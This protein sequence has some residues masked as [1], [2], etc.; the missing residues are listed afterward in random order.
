MVCQSTTFDTVNWRFWWF[1]S[2]GCVISLPVSYLIDEQISKWSI[3]QHLHTC[4]L[5]IRLKIT[6]QHNN[7]ADNSQ[8]ICIFF[9]HATI[10]L[11]CWWFS[12]LSLFL[13]ERHD[14]LFR[15]FHVWYVKWIV[16]ELNLTAR[17]NAIELRC[18][19]PK[20]Q[21]HTSISSCHSFRFISANY[22]NSRSNWLSDRLHNKQ[23][24]KNSWL[25]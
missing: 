18:K 13:D 20:I 17:S 1:V 24:N 8:L 7:S 5:R 21:Q 3:S 16:R 2:S 9:A 12:G 6:R 19:S 14:S 4:W 15:K 11:F 10:T 25:S 23:T 22:R